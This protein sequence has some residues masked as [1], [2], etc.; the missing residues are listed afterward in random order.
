MAE[1]F[2]LR[3]LKS[4]WNLEDRFAGWSDIPLSSEGIKEAGNISK[5]LF[6]YKINK[7][8]SSPL[9]RNMDTVL[10]IFEN[11]DKYP[12]FFHLDKGRMQ[13]W[14]KFN[15]INNNY[16]P[17]FVSE[18][19]NERY[20]GKLQGFEREDIRQKYGEERFKAWRRGYGAKPP[21]GE[22]LKDTFKRTVP[23]YKKYIEKDL[24][25][26]NNILIVGS[27]NSLRSIV[28]YI[29]KISDKEISNVEIPYGGLIKYDFDSSLK[30]INKGLI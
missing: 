22:S 8:Y 4:Q 17:V 30:I 13:K 11:Y 20:Y 24:K 25:K 6:Q 21:E 18:N 2:L 10:R 3:H 14:G 29:E 27:H 15:D 19:I 12:I 1:L 23:F 16:I 9:I 28:K 7:A 26:G 5:K